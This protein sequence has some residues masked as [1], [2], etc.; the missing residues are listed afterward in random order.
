MQRDPDVSVITLSDDDENGLDEFIARGATPISNSRRISVLPETPDLPSPSV[1]LGKEPDEESLPPTPISL[2]TSLLLCQGARM[3]REDAMNIPSSPP[4]PMVDSD[5]ND[6]LVLDDFI[7]ANGLDGSPFRLSSAEHAPPFMGRPAASVEFSDATTE[8]LSSS[9]DD[10]PLGLLCDT[11][12]HMPFVNS[13]AMSSHPTRIVFKTRTASLASDPLSRVEVPPVAYRPLR[14]SPPRT[15][16]T[17]TDANRRERARRIQEQKERERQFARDLSAANKKK[18]EAKDIA[19]DVTV[20]VDPRLLELLEDGKKGGGMQ[21]RSV[22]ATA[23]ATP[24]ALARRS[25]TSTVE[26]REENEEETAGPTDALFAQLRAEGIQCRVE[27][28]DTACAVRWEMRSRRKWDPAIRMYVPLT[29]HSLKRTK[30]AAM[31][32]LGSARFLDLVATRR[33][34]RLAEIWRAALAVNRVFVVVLGLQSALRRTASVGTREFDRQMRQLLKDGTIPGTPASGRPPREDACTEESV[35]LAILEL[36][37]ACPWITWF[38]QCVDAKALGRLL[39]RTTVDLALHELTH[40]EDGAGA[41]GGYEPGVGCFITDDVAA[42]L[43]VAAIKTGASLKESWAL[44]LAQIP[45]VTLPMAQAIAAKY[46]TPQRLFAAWAAMHPASATLLSD[47]VVPS[48]SSG[49]RRLGSAMS[50][51]IYRVL[52]EPDPARPFAEL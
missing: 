9:S 4:L 31:V 32:V 46:P 35:E 11:E 27:V 12:A 8:L 1:F 21:Q 13:R 45:K 41:G 15:T 36:Q 47:I 26:D 6:C 52:N 23:P 28:Q 43:Q 42:A 48:A 49:G 14:S 22:S 30:H 40:K 24:R 19:S 50:A 33:V 51:R 37:L 29:S 7:S 34:Q 25:N 44:A 20:V 39:H 5:S 38:T 17:T 3:C 10:E 2:H 16:K 18:L